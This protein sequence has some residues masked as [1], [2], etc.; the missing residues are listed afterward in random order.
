[1]TAEQFEC[2][3]P[4]P[5]AFKEGVLYCSTNATN[6]V[7]IWVAAGTIG[8]AVAAVGLAAW[9]VYD[10]RKKIKREDQTVRRTVLTQEGDLV[11]QSLDEVDRSKPEEL[12]RSLSKAAAAAR[13]FQVRAASFGPSE[14]EFSADLSDLVFGLG[15][16]VH[17]IVVAFEH[18]ADYKPSMYDLEID[19]GFKFDAAKHLIQ[20]GVIQVSDATTKGEVVKVVAGFGEESRKMLENL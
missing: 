20:K 19:F 10:S 8:S 12:F 14:R 15:M 4:S 6:A 18:D 9:T 7:D 1:M 13:K 11:T 17:N 2:L 5:D 3:I 16:K